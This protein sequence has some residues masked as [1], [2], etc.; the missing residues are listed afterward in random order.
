MISDNMQAAINDQI[1]AEL[2]SSYLYLSM[3]GYYQ[4]INLPGFANWMR[5]QAQEELVHA[6]MFY[7]F[8][9]ERGG[10]VRLQP[11]AG[12]P[13]TWDTPSEPFAQAYAHETMV[14]ARINNLVNLAIDERDHATN[15]FLDWF[16]NEQVE[17]EA[18]ADAIVKQLKLIGGAGNGLFMIDRELATRIFAM[19]AAA[20]AMG[21]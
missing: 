3:A 1:N 12:P 18:N 20:T 14:T 9:N 4:N 2:Y 16:I 19:P 15:T 17:E 11:I 7:T 6:M 8:L 5:V 13:T 21:L 10:A